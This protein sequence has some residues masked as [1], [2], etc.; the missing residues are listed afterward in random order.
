[1][2]AGQ[3]DR[4]FF[5]ESVLQEAAEPLAAAVKDETVIEWERASSRTGNVTWDYDYDAEFFVDSSPSIQSGYICAYVYHVE[6][7]VGG[8]RRT[9]AGLTIS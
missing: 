5:P 1:V 7:P 3:A 2:V 4:M 8:P 6:K 9:R